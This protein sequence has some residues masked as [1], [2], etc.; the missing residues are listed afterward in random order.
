MLE[1]DGDPCMDTLGSPCGFKI[2][3][4]I[5]FLVSGEIRYDA[6]IRSAR[7]SRKYVDRLYCCQG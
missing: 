3:I 4:S 5:L 1:W 7:L 2:P 6:I